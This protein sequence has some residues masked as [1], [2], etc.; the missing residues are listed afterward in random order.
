MQFEWIL[1]I[2]YSWCFFEGKSSCN[3]FMTQVHQRMVFC[4][5][6]SQTGSVLLYTNYKC[7]MLMLAYTFTLYFFFYNI[8]CFL[9]FPKLTRCNSYVSYF[10]YF[11]FTHLLVMLSRTQVIRN[12]DF[13]KIILQIVVIPIFFFLPI[14]YCQITLRFFLYIKKGMLFFSQFV[15]TL[16]ICSLNLYYSSSVDPFVKKCSQIDFNM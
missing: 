1:T 14:I 8:S 13:F 3:I 2:F 16:V 7:L 11:C 6:C 12:C 10:K 9:H 4:F 5:N 15:C